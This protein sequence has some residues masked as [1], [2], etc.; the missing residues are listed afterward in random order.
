[1]EQIVRNVR[2]IEAKE[3]HALE[4]VV[5]RALREEEVLIIQISPMDGAHQTSLA[6]GQQ[7]QTLSDWTSVYEGLSSEQID[8]ID[9]ISTTRAKLTRN[10]P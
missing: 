7:T 4:H 9:T 3:R 2:D 6:N 8:A 10:V 5:G 1:M